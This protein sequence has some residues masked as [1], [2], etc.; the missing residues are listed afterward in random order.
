MLEP[1]RLEPARLEPA[2]DLCEH[3][4]EVASPVLRAARKRWGSLDVQVR[5]RPSEVVTRRIITHANPDGDAL[6]SAWLAERYLFAGE[7]AE[8]LFVPRKRVLGCLRP[9]DCL[10]DV[11]NAFDPAHHLFDHKPPALPS[12]HD[13]CAA[14]CP[15]NTCSP[16]VSG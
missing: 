9:G 13:S 4:A 10:V 1:A 6:V 7:A 11:G 5:V 2:L 15:G 12:R 14:N 3:L 8:V 16:G